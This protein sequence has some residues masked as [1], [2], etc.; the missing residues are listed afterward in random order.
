MPKI[1][2]L[3]VDD[4]V[5]IKEV[6]KEKIDWVRF[7]MEISKTAGSGAEA[8][9]YLEHAQ[10]DLVITDIKMPH[11]DGN[12]LI[13][14]VRARNRDVRF[15]VFS[16]YTDYDIVRKSFK[17]G[18]YDYLQKSDIGTQTM[19]DILMRLRNEIINK[20]HLAAVS[21]AN[22]D[23]PAQL[24]HGFYTVI[25]FNFRSKFIDGEVLE[26]LQFMNSG[27]IRPY[28]TGNSPDSLTLLIAHSQASC[29]GADLE[30]RELIGHLRDCFCDRTDLYI[31]V[32][33]T[34]SGTQVEYL[35]AEAARAA[36]DD[37]YAPDGLTVVCYEET[38]RA[39]DDPK[40]N[41]EYWRS[42]I[43][44]Q[45]TALNIEAALNRMI[46]MMSFLD[47]VRPDAGTCREMVFNVYYFCISFMIDN[48]IL[49]LTDNFETDHA[50]INN[51]VSQINKFSK[52]HK[53]IEENLDLLKYRFLLRYK[54]NI[55]DI[56]KVY[57]SLNLAED[58]S[59]NQIAD[60]YGINNSYIS[61]LFK[62]KEGISLKHY[63]NRMRLE[64]ARDFLA[65]TSMK[66]KD[67]CD[68][69]G[70]NNIEHFSRSF[71]DAY[72]TSPLIYREKTQACAVPDAKPGKA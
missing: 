43:R 6:L 26:I 37:Y 7:D 16:A 9:A 60:Y 61:H 38:L 50:T 40:L 65:N 45:L 68:L 63:V 62:Q 59:L 64:R 69:V 48:R 49:D 2:V 30:K 19:N 35:E 56:I 3:L 71:K 14:K 70:Y 5:M 21:A 20:N 54:S 22:I 31:G 52:L 13:E 4:E 27:R 18:I 28:V 36:A 42:K 15:L 10:V 41:M 23:R 34:R 53:W 39:V 32:S 24:P 33:S 44:E 47:R 8:L 46:D 17:L 51:I 25:C 58:L 29:R 55:V 72:G 12:E 66:I 67:V 1:K 11:M 57:I